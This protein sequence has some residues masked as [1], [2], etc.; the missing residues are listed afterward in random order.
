M[1]HTPAESGR[2]L[3][4]TAALL[5][6]A[7]WLVFWTFHT[8]AHGPRN[9]APTDGTFLG[10]TALE[11]AQRMLLIA[12]PLLTVALIGMLRY[13]WAGL[14]RVGRTGLLCTCGALATMCLVSAGLGPW[15]LYALSVVGLCLGLFLLGLGTRHLNDWPMWSRWAPL[16]TSIVIPLIVVARWP[17]S[18]LLVAGP[19]VGY[20]LLEGIGLA[21]A[22]CWFALGYGLGWSGRPTTARNGTED[23]LYLN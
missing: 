21:L 14:G 12:P 5:G 23:A 16:A 11:H 7:I 2:R 4:G 8:I 1:K 6:G 3:A 18:P 15:V 10:L 20:A 13:E 9:P 17:G 22:L 19:A